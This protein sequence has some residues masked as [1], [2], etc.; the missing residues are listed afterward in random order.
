MMQITSLNQ[1]RIQKAKAA[2]TTRNVDL[3]FGATLLR[4]NVIPQA[5]NLVLA[6]VV[7]IGQHARIELASGRRAH[8]FPGDEIIVCYGDRYAPDQF[9][10]Q[11]PSDLASCHLVAAGGIAARATAQ[12]Y[13]MEDPTTIMPIGLIG[14]NEGEPINLRDYAL[15]MTNFINKT[16]PIF[17]VVGT[18]MNSGKTTTAAYLIRGL[19]EAG[20]RV[21]AAKITGTG[22][23]RDVGMMRDAGAV[24]VLDFTDLGFPATYRVAPRQIEAIFASLVNHLSSSNVD[25]IVLEIA[26]GLYQAETAHLISS[27]ILRQNLDGVLFATS[28]ALGAATGVTMLQERELPILAISGLVTASPLATRETQRATDFPV[29]SPEMIATEASEFM[30]CVAKPQ[31]ALPV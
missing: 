20:H 15:S 27:M 31:L 4:G 7:E 22:S 3:G 11:V 30:A 24:K 23:G 19:T 28:D 9:E 17:T 5:G 12:H 2:Y 25:V 10:A 16:A 26:D 29:F 6:K 1:L 21:G 18:S 14:N 13:K 8:L